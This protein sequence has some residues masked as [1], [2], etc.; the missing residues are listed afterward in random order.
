MKTSFPSNRGQEVQP[1]GLQTGQFG[2]I[3]GASPSWLTRRP[4]SRR[5]SAFTLVEILVTM[6]LLSFIVL[7]LLMMFNQTQRAFR[8]G[9]AQTDVLEGGRGAMDVVVRDLEQ[10]TPCEAPDQLVNKS[11]WMFMYNFWTALDGNVVQYLSPPP[12]GSGPAILRTNVIQQFFFL[13]RNNQD[14]IA[15]YYRVK[16]D[17]VGSPVGSLYRYTTNWP[18]YLPPMIGHGLSQMRTNGNYAALDW[19]SATRIV[20][21]VVHLH[22]RVFDTNGVPLTSP[23]QYVGLPNRTLAAVVNPYRPSVTNAMCYPWPFGSGTPDQMNYMFWNNATPGYIELELGI[24]EP[25]VLQH[26]RAIDPSTAAAQNYLSNHVGEVHLFRQRVPI[27][28]VDFSAYQ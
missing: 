25:K 5:A 14:W 18:R 12:S 4:I 11:T 22:L 8:S 15:N 26:Y 6:T 16:P 23:F 17:S 2:H 20:D 27:R 7:G 1:A 13:S 21:G 28:N 3:R 19:F 10:M 9:L 24:L